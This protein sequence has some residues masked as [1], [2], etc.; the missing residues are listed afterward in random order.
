MLA[1]YQ[2]HTYHSIKIYHSNQT[3]MYTSAKNKTK[4]LSSSPNKTVLS[5]MSAVI[6]H[7]IASYMFQ[8]CFANVLSQSVSN[9]F[10]TISV[11]FNGSCRCARLHWM[12]RSSILRRNCLL[13]Q[14]PYRLIPKARRV[15]P[16]LSYR[17]CNLTEENYFFRT[18]NTFSNSQ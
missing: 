6:T 18:K 3:Y 5:L 17:R 15:N 1:Y 13:Q 14:T 7:P 4:S 12:T 2:C 8:N 16:V 11:P 10:Q 9:N